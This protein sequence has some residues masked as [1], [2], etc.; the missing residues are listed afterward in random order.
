MFSF[1]TVETDRLV[2][3]RISFN[4]SNGFREIYKF[5]NDKQGKILLYTTWL[6]T[7][8]I[9]IKSYAVSVDKCQ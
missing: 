8:V 9:N 6:V 5:N 2:V 4:A 7:W 3:K 1:E